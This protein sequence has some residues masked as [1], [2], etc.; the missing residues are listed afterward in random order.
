MSIGE[1]RDIMFPKNPATGA[2]DGYGFEDDAD[3]LNK[4]KSI[5][6]SGDFLHEVQPGLVK[7]RVKIR[8]SPTSTMEQGIAE[9]AQCWFRLDHDKKPAWVASEDLFWSQMVSRM[10]GGIEIRDYAPAEGDH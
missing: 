5:W 1:I 7:C 8:L 10:Y 9:I 4:L 2:R 3:E 6:E